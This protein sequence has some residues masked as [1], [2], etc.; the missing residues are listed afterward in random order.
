M[1][2]FIAVFFLSVTTSTKLLSSQI[3]GVILWAAISNGGWHEPASGGQSICL[4]G[5]SSS[6]CSFGSA[7]GFFAVAAAI[8]LLIMDARFEKISAIQTRKRVV[9]MDLAVSGWN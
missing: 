5:N 6:A 4:Y 1:Y 2:S 7:M 9:V 3:S 8:L